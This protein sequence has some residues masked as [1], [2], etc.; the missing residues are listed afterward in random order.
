[1]R[2]VPDDEVAVT[3]SR[4]GQ[5]VGF[6]LRRLR[7]WSERG[8]VRP[9]VSRKLS[10]RNTVRL[11]R[12]H[13]LV[14]LHVAK[15]LLNGGRSPQQ[16]GKVVEHLRA[17]DYAA[18]LREL[19]FAVNGRH[20]YFQHPDGTWEGDQAPHQVVLH[21]ILDLE[22]IRAIVRESVAPRREQRR[23]GKVVRRRGVVGGKPVFDGTRIP[24]SAV[25]PYLRRGLSDERIF[26]AFPLLTSD[27]IDV[28]RR[29]LAS[30]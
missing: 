22:R 23:A 5:M 28:A 30:A 4:A 3:E 12:F 21:S 18:P 15:A 11:Y 1:M 8:I 16:I 7:A 27:D 10:E 13:D 26:E 14:E 17:R 9:A 29:T 19:V 25:E 2:A 6:S 20:I 24:V